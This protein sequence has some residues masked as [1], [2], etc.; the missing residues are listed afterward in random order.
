MN[1]LLLA[2]VIFCGG[3][4][5]VSLALSE[6]SMEQPILVRADTKEIQIFGRIYAQRFNAAHGEQ[7]HYH[8][9]VWHK[10]TSPTALIETPVDD[11]DFHAEL[12]KLGAKPG[13]NLTMASWTERKHDDHAAPQEKVTGSEIV[14]R[15]AWKEKPEG[16]PVADVFS[17]TSP[18]DLQPVASWR[19][20]GNLDRPFNKN[21][22]GPRPGCLV[23]L[24]SCPSGKVSNGALSIHAYVASPSRFVAN[25]ALLPPDGTPVILTFQIVPDRHSQR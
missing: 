21:P 7:A 22:L 3:M 14:I 25:T 13:D 12:A 19:F 9:L 10:G 2:L 11:L 15:V 18:A 4:T 16:V 20:G 23:C 8:F 5:G 1:R 24:Y 17:S 6:P